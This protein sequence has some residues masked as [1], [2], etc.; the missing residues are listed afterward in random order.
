MNSQRKIARSGDKLRKHSQ[1]QNGSRHRVL[2]NNLC[3]NFIIII[4]QSRC[5]KLMSK[6]THGIVGIFNNHS[7]FSIIVKVDTKT[8][9]EILA[10]LLSSWLDQ[11]LVEK[12]LGCTQQLIPL[13]IIQPKQSHNT[14]LFIELYI[15]LRVIQFMNILVLLVHCEENLG[16]NLEK[17]LPRP[18]TKIHARSTS[19]LV[20]I[21]L[22][23]VGNISDLQ[24]AGIS[25]KK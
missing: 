2:F 8:S 13:P 22:P 18:P 23:K 15:F 16:E 17:R 24:E 19:D 9:F 5:K 12:F 20:F 6:P 3:S 7:C 14:L 10:K 11:L 4:T 21:N 1:R 25:A